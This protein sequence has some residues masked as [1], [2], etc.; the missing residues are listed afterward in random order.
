MLSREDSSNG[1]HHDEYVS[2]HFTGGP[3]DGGIFELPASP[4]GAPLRR[5]PEVLVYEQADVGQVQRD[6]LWAPVAAR[7]AEMS[8]KMSVSRAGPV[9]SRQL[10]PM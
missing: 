4:E 7:R 5:V 3:A 2:V 6:Q 8:R 9:A 10:S 1:V